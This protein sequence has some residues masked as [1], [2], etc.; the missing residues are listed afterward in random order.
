MVKKENSII[1][2]RSSTAVH[3][4]RNIFGRPPTCISY[5]DVRVKYN[6]IHAVTKTPNS[7]KI[8]WFQTAGLGLVILTV[9]VAFLFVHEYFNALILRRN[10]LQTA[11]CIVQFSG[12][13]M[14]LSTIFL[15][16]KNWDCVS[17]VNSMI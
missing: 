6:Q 7:H 3:I 14:T 1:S 15:F 13:I 2:K 8:L 9:G 4:H 16:R 5:L 12:G 10:V 11:I 17:N